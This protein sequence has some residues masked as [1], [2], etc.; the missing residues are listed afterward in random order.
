MSFTAEQRRFNWIHCYCEA[1]R[2]ALVNEL[3]V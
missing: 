1:I 2:P 3:L